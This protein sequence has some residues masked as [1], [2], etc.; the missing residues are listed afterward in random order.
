MWN[1]CKWYQ[2]YEIY[3]IFTTFL[4]TIFYGVRN[5]VLSFPY[6]HNYV[7]AF[8]LQSQGLMLSNV[9]VCVKEWPTARKQYYHVRR[10]SLNILLTKKSFFVVCVRKWIYMNADKRRK[11]IGIFVM[12]FGCTIV[13]LCLPS[14]L[15]FAWMWKVKCS[16]MWQK[17]FQSI[18]AGQS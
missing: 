18:K 16:F 6:N 15:L 17:G 9:T 13:L 5:R 7:L 3:L 14:C 1:K 12:L 10:S 2:K 4:F 11:Y 8:F